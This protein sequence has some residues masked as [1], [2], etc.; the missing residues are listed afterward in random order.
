M[1]FAKLRSRYD[2]VNILNNR[3]ALGSIRVSALKLPGER[4]RWKLR[5]KDLLETWGKLCPSTSEALLYITPTVGSH[6]YSSSSHNTTSQFSQKYT[7]KDIMWRNRKLYKSVTSH[8]TVGLKK[9]S[10]L[11]MRTPKDAIKE[12]MCGLDLPV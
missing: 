12:Y 11:H 9:P 3:T 10:K 8:R 6:F 5:M 2:I 7:T 1:H 4:S